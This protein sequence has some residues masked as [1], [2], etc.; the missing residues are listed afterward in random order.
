MKNNLSSITIKDVAKHV[1]VSIATV[2]RELNGSVPVQADKAERVRMVMD[3]LRFVPR[4]A[5]R[6]LASRK[7]NTIGLVLSEI[8]G[9][10]FPLLLKGIESETC[11]HSH[12]HCILLCAKD[13]RSR[14]QVDG[15]ER[16]TLR[17]MDL[18]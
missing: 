9:A 1:G 16:I 7:T 18:L 17:E 5:A 3:D 8:G 13:L 2:S 4:T 12:R 15:F 6:T 11:Y 14:H 10:F